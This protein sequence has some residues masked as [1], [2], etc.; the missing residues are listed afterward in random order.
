MQ[1][2][3]EMASSVGVRNLFS[4]CI[5][6]RLT[7][8]FNCLIIYR[9]NAR[10]LRPL[11]AFSAMA[12]RRI[13]YVFIA[14]LEHVVDKSIVSFRLAGAALVTIAQIVPSTWWKKIIPKWFVWDNIIGF[15]VPTSIPERLAIAAWGS[16]PILKKGS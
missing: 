6:S 9:C 16:D 10:A 5:E 15:C 3:N 1:A 14:F 8:F 12:Y 7:L 2:A 13:V 11:Q 4:S